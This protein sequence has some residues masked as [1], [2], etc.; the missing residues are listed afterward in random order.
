M[1]IARELRKQNIAEYLIYMFHL[2]DLI[3]AYNADI[4]LL[5]KNHIQHFN[6]EK[7]ELTE[8][9]DWY[10][11]F[12]RMMKEEN[13]MERGHLQFLK[14]KMNELESFHVRLLLSSE[15]SYYKQV[16]N[17]CVD[18]LNLFRKKSNLNNCGDVELAITAL[19]MLFLMRLK[20]MEIKNDTLESLERISRCM[21][22]LAK[23]YREFEEG[24]A[25]F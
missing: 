8:T 23:K 7:K 14:N 1:I 2:E 24:I 3:R 16:F 10:A 5:Y 19:Y 4:E 20:K 21:S 22:V 25:E 6:I 18:D 12:C 13:L 9:R 17:E 11:T 15:E